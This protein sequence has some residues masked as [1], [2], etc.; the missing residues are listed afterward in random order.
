VISSASQ[1]EP[2]SIAL[3]YAVRWFREERG[4]SAVDLAIRAPI[5]L[6]EI[7]EIEEGAARDLSAHT[8]CDVAHAL[9]IRASELIAAAESLLA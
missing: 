6:E 3:G 4:L 8:V 5:G 7:V 2:V 1:R 9:D